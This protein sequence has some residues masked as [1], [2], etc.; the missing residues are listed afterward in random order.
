MLVLV[1]CMLLV[2]LVMA[3]FSIDVAY[4]HLTRV[5]LRTATDASARAGAEALSRLQSEA[6]ASA[7]ASRIAYQNR[8]AGKPLILPSSDIEFGN[9][10][11]NTGV[12][13]A[14]APNASSMRGIRIHG[15]R[16]AASASGSVGLLM[17]GILGRTTF[18][19]QMTA[20]A[21]NLDRDICLVVD[22]SGSMNWE[23][24]SDDLPPNVS[25]CM[26]PD[27]QH[28]RWGALAK[29]F[30]AF[31]LELQTTRP[32]EHLGLVSYSSSGVFC[33][34]QFSESSI[35]A[36]LGASY[37]SAQ[38]A[39]NAW[40]TGLI[41]GATN[42][43]AGVQSGIDVLTDSSRSR[44]IAHRVMIVLT[45]GVHNRGPTP[46]TLAPAV[47]ANHIVIHT[48]TFSDVADQ[49]GMQT[50]AQLTG[51]QHYHATT[52]SALVGVFREIAGALPV[53]LTE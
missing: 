40:S 52:V 47:N 53:V 4:M 16:D 38:N 41:Q 8:I 48:I 13:S 42:I 15:R 25:A 51:G 33:G 7:A 50:L 24:T 9:V 6:E 29:A 2:L 49:A 1:A 35:D 11:T 18:E 45:D 26:A 3:I 43:T 22:R 5:Q 14:G 20:V 17:G 44:P 28:S 12:F 23:L 31:I 37:A 32:F 46:D 21:A 30:D 19:P 39:M 27:P 10:D 34:V 36:P